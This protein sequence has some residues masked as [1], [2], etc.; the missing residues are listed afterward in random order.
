MKN[1][2]HEHRFLHKILPILILFLAA[3]AVYGNTLNNTF[4]WDDEGAILTNKYIH[5]WGYFLNFFSEGMFA[6]SGSL[7]Y[8]WR[9]VVLSIFSI[10][11]HIFHEWV[12]GYHIVNILLH[13]IDAILIFYLFRLIFYREMLAFAA[14][15]FFAIHPLQTE[16][17]TYISGISDP[18]VTFFILFG[19]VTYIKA[20][21]GS[22]HE[23]L[24]LL[25][26]LLSFI[27]ALMSKE[28]AIMM[29]GILF[30]SDLF[31]RRNLAPSWYNIKT[32]LEKL[33][34]LFLVLALYIISRLTILNFVKDLPTSPLSIP[35]YERTLTFF[36]AFSIYIRLLFA[37]FHLHMEW[38]LPVEKTIFSVPVL[39]GIFFVV[40]FLTLIITQYKK[41]PEVSFGL[42]W[43]LIALSPSMNI[44]IP[45]T[46]LL[47]EH[48]LYIS[49][50][51]FFLAFF[52]L[53][54]EFFRSV[55]LRTLLPALFIVWVIWLSNITILR[56]R[57]WANPITFFTATLKEAPHSYRAEVNLGTAY[58]KI[59]KYETALKYYKNAIIRVPN[60]P[61]AYYERAL[62][63]QK[64]GREN[65]AI[66][67]HERSFF[68]SPAYSPSFSI[69]VD[70][71]TTHRKYKKIRE[72]LEARLEKITEPA[73]SQKI[74]LMLFNTAI[75]EKNTTLKKEYE[76]RLNANESSIKNEPA[77]KFGTFLNKYFK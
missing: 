20:K 58:S 2:F 60:E 12:V 48:W 63:Y 52:A 66:R 45:T 29:P 25:A 10:E 6:G 11:W 54:E 16:A 40:I 62:V 37:P 35:L 34:P 77:V 31:T 75:Q 56:N 50:P 39:I 65:D 7:S 76:D 5:E 43:F 17:V 19:T 22:V 33:Y 1:F 47:S 57:D 59:G 41:R 46:A 64:M 13:T 32:S 42:M 4:L 71:F 70:Y 72:I 73:E 26:T 38:A 44:F 55:F 24:F 36:H 14:A 18:L 9:P 8:Y 49:L 61:M 21:E 3:F 28:S 15:L 69:L 74:L 51:G 27:F 53:T 23:R 68:L 67:D 30:L